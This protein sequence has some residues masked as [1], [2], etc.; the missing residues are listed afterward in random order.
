MSSVLM[1]YGPHRFSIDTFGYEKIKRAFEARIASQNIIGARPSLHKMG[2]GDETI[3]ITAKFFPFHLP[4]NRGL[5][6]L[7]RMRQDVG[8]SHQLVGNRIVVGDAFGRWALKK[9]G[10]TGEHIAPNGV[11]QEI[12]VDIELLYDGRGRSTA[13]SQAIAALFGG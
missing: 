3:R 5:S 6:Q 1:E 11:P 7:S 8:S 13:A 9:V 12:S 4:G 10:D 2:Y